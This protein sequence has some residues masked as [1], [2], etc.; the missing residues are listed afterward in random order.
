MI[1]GHDQTR[2]DSSDELRLIYQWIVPELQQVEALMVR[3]LASGDPFVNEVIRYG[4]QFGGKKLRPALVLLAG[5]ALGTLNGNHLR[6]AASL[7]MI[8]TATLIHD[9]ILDGARIRRHLETMNMRWDSSVAVLAGDLLFTQAMQLT[10]RSDDIFEY[11]AL[12]EATHVTCRAELKQTSIRGNF[13]LTRDEY[14]GM[15]SGKTAALLACACRMGAYFSGANE[16]AQQLFAQ[17]GQKLGIA[18][19]I[20]DD[21]LDLVGR[22]QVVGK[23]L[24]TDIREG[25]LTLPLID[26]FQENQDCQEMLQFLQQPEKDDT[27]IQEIV[28]LLEQT[29]FIE[30]SRQVAW[31]LVQEAT[32][33][34][35]SPPLENIAPQ[36]R[37][38]L[39]NIALYVLKRKR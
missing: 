33:I 7:E 38:A 14:F 22:E 5:K 6:C 30:S 23:T 3:E 37:D 10:T 27:T 20:V 35:D 16:K 25:K 26:F 36:A 32:E 2:T 34:L 31:N 9:D 8:H 18:F 29:G 19:Q 24:G 13:N 12:A 17:F 39:K 21:V 1:S 15:I 28:A 11:R 4:F